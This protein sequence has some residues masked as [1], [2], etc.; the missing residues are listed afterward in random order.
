[1]NDELWA[2]QGYPRMLT[3]PDS[4]NVAAVGYSL[5]NRQMFVVFKGTPDAVYRYDDVSPE[6]AG[7]VFGAGSVGKAIGHE[8]KAAGKAYT[9]LPVTIPSHT[10]EGL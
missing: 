6:A 2:S 5:E 8:L 7:V 9:R 3:I 10:V 1:M 4:S